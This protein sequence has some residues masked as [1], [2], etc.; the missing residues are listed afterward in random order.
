MNN[1]GEGHPETDDEEITI[2]KF[3]IKIMPTCKWLLDEAVIT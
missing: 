1:M 2:K 3:K